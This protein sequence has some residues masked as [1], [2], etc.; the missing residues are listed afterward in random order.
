MGKGEIIPME[1]KKVLII[2]YYYPPMNN[3]GIQRIINF[4]KYL[5]QFGYDVYILTTDSY[6]FTEDNE[7]NVYR[8]PDAGY[9]YV[10]KK[11]V[12]IIKKFL[13]RIIRRIEVESG[14]ITDGKFYWK[15]EVLKGIGQIF[16]N[17]KFDYVIASYPTPANLEIGEYIYDKYQIPLI[18]DYR[19]G[20]MYEPFPEIQKSFFVYKKRLKSLEKRL[21][22]KAVFQLSVNKDICEYYNKMYPHVKTVMITNGFDDKEK[23]DQAPLQLPEGINMLYT[24]GIGK[25]RKNYPFKKLKKALKYIFEIGEKINFIFIGEYEA[26]EIKLFQEYKNVYVYPKTDRKIVVATQKEADAFLLISGPK[27]GTSGKLYEYLFAKHPILNIGGKNEVSEIINGKEFGSTY[28]LDER[29][30]MGKFIYDLQ[31]GKLSYQY[32]DVKK[33]SREEQ[34]KRFAAAMDSDKEKKECI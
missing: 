6:G 1:R 20:L 24:G 12:S 16:L 10:H 27:S 32:S 21:A 31:K 18:V 4:K 26:D 28:S 8:F 19:D 13:F 7:E 30:A 5:P 17:E 29:E 25:S 34:C 2:S 23:F 3:G 14:L 22:D 9:D 11:N 33:Y 15:K